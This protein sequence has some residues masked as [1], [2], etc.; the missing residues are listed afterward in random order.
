MGERQEL[1]QSHVPFGRCHAECMV[2]QLKSV[3]ELTLEQV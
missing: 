2:S 3:S 1:S